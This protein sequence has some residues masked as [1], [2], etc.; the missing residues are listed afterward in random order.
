M[1]TL[2]FGMNSKKKH[3]YGFKDAAPDG[4][5]L[6]RY[7]VAMAWL[8]AR[9]HVPHLEALRYLYPPAEEAA[10]N[11]LNFGADFPPPRGAHHIPRL[12]DIADDPAWLETARRR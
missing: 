3:H 5:R 2:R 6:V 9:V 7:R 10:E 4:A 1:L 11:A 8:R 12:D